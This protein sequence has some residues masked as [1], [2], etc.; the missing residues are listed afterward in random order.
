[1]HRNT[2]EDITF[3][4]T[5]KNPMKGFTEEED[6]FLFYSMFENGYGN[7]YLL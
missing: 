2:M 3:D 4:Y 7:W 6:R 1:M 5:G